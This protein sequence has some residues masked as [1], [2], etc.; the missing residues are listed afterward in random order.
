M[1]L[2]SR[3]VSAD[4]IILLLLATDTAVKQDGLLLAANSHP[5]ELALQT[6]SYM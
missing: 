6:Y 5:L 3:F 2:E 4:L 1:D